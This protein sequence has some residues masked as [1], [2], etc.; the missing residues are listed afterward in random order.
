MSLTL[1]ALCGAD[2]A[3]PFSPHVWKV[4]MALAHKGLS[5][6][7]VAV[8]FTD[9]PGIE[10]GATKTVPL[11]KDGET[12]VS[13]SFAI[14]RYLEE[15]YPDRPSLFGGPGG[16]ATARLVE[17]WSQTQIHPLLTPILILD[18]HAMLAPIDQAYF[19]ESREK[20]LGR[21]L[22]EAAAGAPAAIADLRTRLEPLR[23]TLRH[24]PFIG[25]ETP[26]FADYIVFGALQW[27][28]TTSK[29]EILG[30]DDPVALW[31]D[32]CLDLHGALGRSVTAA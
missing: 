28:R 30:A 17:G 13:D 18:I 20:R 15:T 21:T 8:G 19:R 22:E 29:T 10:A 12:L 7:T 9:I 23:H 3:R 6:Q 27:A 2:P 4:A 32:R 14:A 5:A 25:G 26:L 31:F 1:Y 11:L 16:L 24:Q